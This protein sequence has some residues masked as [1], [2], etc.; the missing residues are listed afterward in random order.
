MHLSEDNRKNLEYI[1]IMQHLKNS[2][3]DLKKTYSLGEEAQAKCT[4]EKYT[5][6]C[7]ENNLALVSTGF[8]YSRCWKC[9]FH[10]CCTAD[11]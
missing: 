6:A 8:E 10:H 2:P 9:G 4:Q 1:I 5:S 11:T 7:K 3:V